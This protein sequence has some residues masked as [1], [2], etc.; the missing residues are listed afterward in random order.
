MGTQ[1]TTAGEGG[2]RMT[3]DEWLR[4]FDEELGQLRPHLT[5]EFVLTIAHAFHGD[6]NPRAA[7]REY[8]SQTQERGWRGYACINEQP[9]ERLIAVTGV[10]AKRGDSR[11]QGAA[12]ARSSHLP[13]ETSGSGP[14]C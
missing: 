4:Q 10:R 11:S 14:T 7:A 2:A 9:L 5:E 3:R 6:E 12:W 1:E 13:R 8:H